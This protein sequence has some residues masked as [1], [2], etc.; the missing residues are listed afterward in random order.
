MKNF[1]YPLAIEGTE[2]QLRSVYKELGKL[3]YI[4]SSPS[5]QPKLIITMVD[6]SRG[7]AMCVS[8]AA[9]HWNLTPMAEITRTRV[10][11]SN[12]GL[13]MALAAM[14]DDNIPHVGEAVV[15]TAIGNIL[16]FGTIS[17]ITSVAEHREL[18]QHQGFHIHNFKANNKAG[19]TSFRQTRK[20]T[21]D[22]I[23][24]H[25]RA[26]YDI[27]SA[28]SL[29]G[30]KLRM[31]PEL[32]AVS[33]IGSA[34]TG[35]PKV[36]DK[37]IIGY[38]LKEEFKHITGALEKII[39]GWSWYKHADNNLEGS[40][41]HFAISNSDSEKGVETQLRKY[42]VLDLWFNPVYKKEKHLVTGDYAV[43][44]DAGTANMNS[45][46][47]NVGVAYKLVEDLNE[48]NG[49]IAE[50]NK[51]DANGW[52]KAFNIGM[53]FRPATQEEINK[54]KP[55]SIALN[56]D[57]GVFHVEVSRKGVFYA[58][59]KSW[60]EMRKVDQLMDL[61]S[62]GVTRTSEMPNSCPYVFKI[63]KMDLGCMKNVSIEDCH[64]VYAA[65]KSFR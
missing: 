17:I 47:F 45:I 38:I 50:D 28:K 61:M 24:K 44:V 27:A 16:P 53:K 43:I 36:S 64:K 62:I 21:K 39:H 1:K 51:G 42:G 60:I 20:A 30:I 8:S 13:V 55:I 48:Y 41:Y 37:P 25:F 22:E 7:T 3:G 33:T 57:S 34:S 46:V 5:Y 32:N 12:F 56:S 63:S 65:W 35:L 18:G 2:E 49:F 10:S 26:E 14:V 9:D 54:T 11:A 52:R 4:T 15:W 40:G 58:P 59:D 6:G 29:G 19:T 23:I 31:I